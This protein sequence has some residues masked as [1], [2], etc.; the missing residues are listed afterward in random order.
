MKHLN[1]QWRCKT[2]LMKSYLHSASC[3]WCQPLTQARAWIWRSFHLCQN[4]WLKRKQKQERGSGVSLMCQQSL[5]ALSVLI[6]T[7]LAQVSDQPAQHLFWPALWLFVCLLMFKMFSFLSF[8][9]L[10]LHTP[11]RCVTNISWLLSHACI[12]SMSKSF[13]NHIF[14]LR[15]MS[16][17]V[18]KAVL[19]MSDYFPPK[20][21]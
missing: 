9:I 1:L 12:G 2:A 17:A 11:A 10:L 18:M 13:F 8:F 3:P 19:I 5:A 15:S 16:S 14:S 4:G 21:H 6:F 20:M 7:V